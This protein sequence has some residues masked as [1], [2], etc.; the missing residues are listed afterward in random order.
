MK[1]AFSTLACPTWDFAAIAARAKEFGYGGV[2]LRGYLDEPAKTASN[3]FLTDARRVREIFES[4]GTPIACLTSA[5]MMS[6]GRRANESAA[7]ALRTYIETAAM[8]NCP[9]VRL[10]DRLLGRGQAHLK[11]AV[12][13]GEW[14]APLAEF[15]AARRV[16][17]AVG[18]QFSFRTA[19]EMWTLLETVN[20]PAVGAAWDVT[21]AAA[22][23][24]SPAIS[25][26]ALS[27]RIGYAVVGDAK[28][29]ST[30]SRHAPSF[31]EPVM[32][33]EGEVPVKNFLTR[34]MGVGYGGWVSFEWPKVGAPAM[35]DP[36]LAL[37][38]ALAKLR[39]W[40]KLQTGKPV[41]K[42]HAT[43]K[44]AKS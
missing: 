5:V 27:G 24:E 11:G 3:V 7:R 34:L 19:R 41:K 38:A 1:L 15:A 22:V 18:N 40:T 20:H 12:E 26:P 9:I 36:E 43:V 32:L 39:E 21:S 10:P 28:F 4:A 17:L 44:V 42:E 29:L 14:L 6:D 16:T 37:P 35:L 33:G 30:G 2:E 8:L 13:M 31:I 25:V 23:G